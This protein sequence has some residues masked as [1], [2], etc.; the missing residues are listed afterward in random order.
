MNIAETR[1][2]CKTFVAKM[3]RDTLIIG[4]LIL[5]SSAS[6]GLGYLAGMDAGQG[7]AAASAESPAEP[8]STPARQVVASKNG[9]KYYLP[10]CAGANRISDA[11]RVWFASPAAAESAGY[12]PAANCSGM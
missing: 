5:A 8:L 11:N 6:F 2:K 4:V 1:E 9:T 3:P 12:A 7:S 10:E